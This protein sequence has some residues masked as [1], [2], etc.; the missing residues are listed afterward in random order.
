MADD[1]AYRLKEGESPAAGI[2]RIAA[3]RAEK[4]IE[5]LRGAGEA[6]DLAEA[7]HSARKDLKKLRGVLRLVRVELGE[8]RFRAENER[9]R[10]AARRL[11]A[12]RDAEV[13]LATL[14]ALAQR[15]TGELPDD[16]LAEWQ[17]ALAGERAARVSDAVLAVEI[18]RTIGEIQVG[19]E[20]IGRWRLSTDSWDRLGPGFERTYRRGRR[21]MRRAGAR[22]KADDV[23]E[24][25]KRVKDLWYQLRIVRDAWPPVIGAMADQAHELAELLGEH[26]DLALLRDD[27]EGRR[28]L[29]NTEAL[30][31]AIDGR[32][33]ELLD[34]ALG[35]G[36]RL[37]AEKPKAFRRRLRVYWDLLG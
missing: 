7:I 33:G 36:A 3:G 34:D 8:E 31:A 22:R 17:A 15:F 28:Q 21:A 19:R 25:R 14:A 6:G 20:E 26:H 2:E 37:Y 27:L 29:P 10:E 35:L 30:A 32:Q 5:E 13:K 11:S 24:W 23:H 12:S 16:S 9:Y 4:A 18:E 1:R